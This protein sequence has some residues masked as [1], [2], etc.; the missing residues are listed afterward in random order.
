MLS[1]FLATQIDNSGYPEKALGLSGW[2]KVRGRQEIKHRSLAVGD[3]LD[4]T[5]FCV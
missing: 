3:P 1:P 4:K 5:L 2:L